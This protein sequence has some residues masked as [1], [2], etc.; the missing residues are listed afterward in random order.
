MSAQQP[1][2]EQ[3]KIYHYLDYQQFLR[4]MYVYKKTRIHGF[5]Y[6]MLSRQAGLKSSNFLK[7]VMDGKRHIGPTVIPKVSQ[8][9]KL[10]QDESRFFEWLVLFQQARTHDEKKYYY[11]RL[12]EQNTFSKTVE[13]QRHQ[14]EYFSQWY[15]VA[16]RE[17]VALKD[18]CLEPKWINKQLG[19]KLTQHKI[20]QI[21]KTL[22]D[23][24]VLRKNQEGKLE[25]VE[26][27]IT[28]HPTL[29]HLSLLNFHK[30]MINK[31][32]QALESQDSDQRDI[33]TLTISLSKV[34]F[35]KIRQKIIS[36]RHEIHDLAMQAD[37]K[38]AV[39]Q[40]NLQLFSLTEVPWVQS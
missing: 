6:R 12:M 39:Y 30:T 28:V 2:T 21:Y 14:Y 37:T 26:A 9:F 22:I 7:L 24:G 27:K 31:A 13:L 5:S 11:E 19:L 35:E 40:F 17:L 38:E 3:P 15:Y 18:F 33:S 20:N 1:M 25:Q 10:P 34:Q 32:E 4:D 8:A 29:H 16:L 23:L 36:F